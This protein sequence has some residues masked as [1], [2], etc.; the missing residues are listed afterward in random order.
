M[1]R[2]FYVGPLDSLQDVPRV[3]CGRRSVVSVG[4]GGGGGGGGD[5]ACSACAAAV[6]VYSLVNRLD[7]DWV[8]RHPKVIIRSPHTN[9]FIL[10]LG[11]GIRKLPRKLCQ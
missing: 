9:P 6:I 7:Y 10:V 5:I 11:M 1:R 8:T 3:D 4:V 2:P